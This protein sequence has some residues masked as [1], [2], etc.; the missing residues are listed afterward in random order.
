MPENLREGQRTWWYDL[1]QGGRNRINLYFPIHLWREVGAWWVQLRWGDRKPG[2]LKGVTWLELLVDFELSSGVN[3]MQP[4]G[5]ATWGDRAELLRN[6]GKFVLKVRSPQKEAL[7]TVYGN[8]R[9]ITALA[10]FGALHLGG[11]LRRP[12]FVSGPAASKAIAVNAWQWAEEGKEKLLQK[13][14]VSYTGFKRG[15]FKSSQVASKLDE[16]ARKVQQETKRRQQPQERVTV[17]SACSSP[18]PA[19]PSEKLAARRGRP[20]ESRKRLLSERS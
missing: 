19:S 2:L 3:C 17:P 4:Q 9:R 14:K 12:V 11:L 16:T 6:I 18:S 5:K 15:S 1:A 8:S 13:H 7:E 20:T 10:P